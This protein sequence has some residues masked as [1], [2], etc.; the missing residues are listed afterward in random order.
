M[1]AKNGLFVTAGWD[2]SVQVLKELEH[3][4]EKVRELQN[5]VLG[6]EITVL[7]LSVAHNM[8]AIASAGNAVQLIDYEFVRFLNCIQL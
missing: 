4:F 6:S 7:A 8:L 5:C 3:G 2:S 1:D